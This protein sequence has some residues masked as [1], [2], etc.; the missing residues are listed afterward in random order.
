MTRREILPHGIID[1][2]PTPENGCDGVS[3]DIEI[4]SFLKVVRLMR[5]R[6]APPSTK[7]W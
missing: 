4:Y 7:T 5:L 1:T 3:F 2:R 6:A